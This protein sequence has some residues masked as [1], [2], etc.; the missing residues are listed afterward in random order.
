[1][2]AVPSADFSL[3]RI[4]QPREILVRVLSALIRQVVL[5]AYR[6]CGHLH[7]VRAVF[8]AGLHGDL[9]IELPYAVQHVHAH[10]AVQSAHRAACV[11]YDQPCGRG[12]FHRLPYG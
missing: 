7:A 9:L 10:G 1:M 5:R 8:F 3:Q 11:F 12:L 4:L 6:V 2:A